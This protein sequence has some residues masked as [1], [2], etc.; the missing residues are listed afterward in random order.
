MPDANGARV[1]LGVRGMDHPSARARV[2]STL[3]SV[4]GVLSAEATA[5]AQ[6]AVVYDDSEVTIMDL[7]RSLRRL[8]FLAGME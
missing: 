7:I 6:V 5:D 8:G 2:E 3:R 4:P 1:L